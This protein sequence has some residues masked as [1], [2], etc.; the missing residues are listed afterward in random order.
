MV[1]GKCKRPDPDEDERSESEAEACTALLAAGM[2]WAGVK[3]SQMR[4]AR[5]PKHEPK[6]G[7]SD[8]KARK[9]SGIRERTAVVTVS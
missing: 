8:G 6:G 5:K 7:S 2:G 4:P 3:R 1:K 9:Q